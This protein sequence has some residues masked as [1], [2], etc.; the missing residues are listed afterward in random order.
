M[1]GVTVS[2]RVQATSVIAI[3]AM[4]LACQPPPT[5]LS[6]DVIAK[7]YLET[8]QAL[9]LHD[10]SLIDHWIGEPPSAVGARRPVAELSAEIA[11]LR[12]ALDTP[13]P[14][15]AEGDI[16]RQA[17]LTAQV[18][19]LLVAARRLLG[20]SLPFDEEARLALGLAPHRMDEDAAADVRRR[21]N[22]EL[23]GP[24]SL[25]DRVAAFRQR[26]VI[27][28]ERQEEVLRVALDRCRAAVGTA[29]PLPS[30]ERVD[31]RMVPTLGWDAHAR[32]AGG[33]RT[34]ID[35]KASRPLDLT[36]ALRLACHEGYPGHHVQHL[37]IEDELIGRRGWIEFRLV[38]GFGRQL[39]VA[40]G[41]AEAGADLAM[42]ADRRLADYRDHLAPAAG[43][44]GR[45]LDRLVR[46]EERLAELEPLIG[47][48]AREYLDNAITAATARARLSTEAL[49]ADQDALLPFIERQR[50]R[51]LAY[52]AGRRLVHQSASGVADLRRAFFSSW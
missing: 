40:E 38:P 27:P 30:D 42:P 16:G 35:V 45:D 21:L 48:I 3:A 32:Y 49:V 36:R 44:S 5:S 39:L 51:L 47:D 22:A 17:H 10:P 37:W 29:V 52:P 25:V 15:G 23:P 19:A 34:I 24:G 41:A 13:R 7:R 12:A 28:T 2:A 31:I 8:V 6:L 4:T 43:L 33:H 26:F 18:D 11:G 14:S 20:E 50:T 1:R 46:V 9:G